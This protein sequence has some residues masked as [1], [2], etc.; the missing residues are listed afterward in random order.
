MTSNTTAIRR[1]RVGVIGAGDVAQVVHLPTLRLMYSMYEVVAIC[2]VSLATAQ[3]CAQVF[4]IPTAVSDPE[5]LFKDPQI[6]LIF[7]LTSDEYHEP[8]GIAALQAGKHVM[9][10]KPITLSLASGRRILEAERQAPNGARVFVGYMRRYAASFQAFKREVASIPRIRYARARDIIGQNAY[11][12]GQSGT[13]PR[14]LFDDIPESKSNDRKSRLESLFSEAWGQPAEEIS[15]RRKDYCALLGSLGSH[16][17]SL[18]RDALGRLP[19]AV[20]A[21]RQH[22]TSVHGHVRLQEQHAKWRAIHLLLRVRHRQ[23]PAIRFP[24]GR[25]W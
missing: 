3:H 10:E 25:L 14:K 13:S 19:E 21:N 20:V 24:F 12:I 22:D 16:G 11:F 5:H 23:R 7:I 9:I 18:M 8:Y 4:N 1:L 6:D 2:D 17:L 15:H